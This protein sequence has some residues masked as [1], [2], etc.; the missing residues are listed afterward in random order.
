MCRSDYPIVLGIPDFRLEADPWIDMEADRAKGE[1]LARE[2]EGADFE[3]VVRAYWAM[4]PDTPKP[5]AEKFI[6]HVL[7]SK[8]RSEEWLTW[9][10]AED[11]P[12][13][14]G[15]WVELGCG[16]GDLVVAA[17][18]RG[19]ELIGIDIAFRWLVVASRRPELM[20][21]NQL[22]VCCNAEHLPFANASVA[23]VVS[24]GTL[25][26]CEDASS[27]IRE[28]RR[29]LQ[30]GARLRIRTVNRYT[31]LREPH[32]GVWGV[33]L[34]PRRWADRYVR[35]RNGQRY[36]HHRP[37]SSMELN[38][39]LRRAGFARVRVLGADLLASERSRLSSRFRWTATLYSWARRTI[40]IRTVLGTI[41]P[42]L[43]GT[44]V[45]P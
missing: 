25:E 27:A 1:R 32:V 9:I 39:Q 26:H 7:N 18:A 23:R 20:G 40:G 35:L 29:V 19:T 11:G 34:M 38:L 37:L 36:L 15:R 21:K 42:A 12:A 24:A 6:R 8:A 43:D 30:P 22:L 33:G 41:A 2:T 28:A 45:K 13:P 10:L 5:L 31:L 16:T 4:T 14:T 3:T 44:G 17:Q